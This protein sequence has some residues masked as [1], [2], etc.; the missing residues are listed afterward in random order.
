MKYCSELEFEQKPDY[1][2]L[3]SLF[4]NALIEQNIVLDY[5]FDWHYQKEKILE[6]K[7]IKEEEDI[8]KEIEK[9]NAK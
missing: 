8:Q 5:K 2:Y 9:Q 4:E 7:R 1:K 6:E 3:I